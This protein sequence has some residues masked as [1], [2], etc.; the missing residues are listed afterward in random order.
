MKKPYVCLFF[1]NEAEEARKF[2]L[3]VFKNSKKGATTYYTD[4]MHMKKGTVLTA[5][6][7]IEGQT[8]MALNG[9]ASFPTTPAVSIVAECK[10]QKE[11]DTLWKK[12]L[13]GGGKEIECGWLT[14]KYGVTWQVAP[15]H[16][17][18]W[19]AAR[20]QKKTAR[21]FQAMGGMKKLDIAKL[22]KAFE[23][24]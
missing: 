3:S 10:T 7:E 11:I 24:K 12:L 21:M 22:Q 9:N 6:F 23:G 5:M 2:Y 16:F 4:G 19:L 20:D 13:K 18:K 1:K 14:D 17:H 8:F 15:V